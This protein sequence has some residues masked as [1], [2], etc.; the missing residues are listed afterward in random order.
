MSNKSEWGTLHVL[1]SH[2]PHHALSLNFRNIRFLFL[3]VKINLGDN[4][5]RKNWML[6][7]LGFLGLYGIKGLIT[8]EYL[9]AIWLLW[10]IWFI[11][12][13]AEKEKK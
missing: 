12:F 8:G 13:L 6:G 11:Y 10:F 7:F 1:K 4:M 9:E 2:S 5:K 3:E